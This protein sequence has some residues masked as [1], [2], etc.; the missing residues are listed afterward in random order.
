VT[1]S[2]SLDEVGSILWVPFRKLSVK[3]YIYIYIYI[4]K[5]ESLK[6]PSFES[7]FYFST[8]ERQS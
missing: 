8:N 5:L 6:I 1:L 3:V 4:W 2:S 7:G